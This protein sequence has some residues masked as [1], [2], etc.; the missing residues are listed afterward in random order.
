MC[1]PTMSESKKF[2]HLFVEHLTGCG[3]DLGSQGDPVIPTAIGLDLPHD[4]FLRYN[5]GHPPRGPIQLRGH[6]EKLPFDDKSLDYVFSSNLIEDYKFWGPVLKEW[7]RVLKHGGKLVILVPDKERWNAAIVR[8]QLGNPA[9]QH[10]SYA[11]ELSTYADNL[12]LT[13][14]RDSLADPFGQDYNL[15]FIAQRKLDS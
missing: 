11:G 5:G 13:V 10:E 15:I 7:V 8:G 14:I 12:G 3:V 9:H 4:E 2:L 1:N 6:A